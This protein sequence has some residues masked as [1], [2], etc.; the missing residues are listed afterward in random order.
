MV[1]ALAMASTRLHSRLPQASLRQEVSTQAQPSRQSVFPTPPPHLFSTSLMCRGARNQTMETATAILM[2]RVTTTPWTCL[3]LR[4][5]T[6]DR[7]CL[8]R[9]PTFALPTTTLH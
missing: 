6:H 5:V 9:V 8:G 7:S 4:A 1:L 2:A 3:P